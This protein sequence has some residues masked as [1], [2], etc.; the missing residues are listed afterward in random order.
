MRVGL[1]SVTGKLVASLAVLGSAAA[2]A[3]LGTFGSF[4]STTSSSTAVSSSTVQIALGATG[5]ATNRLNVAASGI[6]PGDTIQRSVDLINSG[7]SNLATI[8]LT[9]TATTTSLLDTTTATGL[10]FV[11]DSCSQAWTEAGVSPAFTYTCGGSLTTLVSSV[12]IIQTNEALPGLN[13]LTAGGTDHLRV[14]MS[15]PSAA[16]NLLQNQSSTISFAFVGTQRVLTN[17]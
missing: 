11:V 13:A 6:V 16:G 1:D 7:T 12:P 14:T 4:T 3:G 5:A 8:T 10:Q 9:T 2:V 17:K 15:L